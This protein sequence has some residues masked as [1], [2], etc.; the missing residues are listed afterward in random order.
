LKSRGSLAKAQLSLLSSIR[1]LFP[2]VSDIQLNYKHPQFSFLE[3]KGNM[4]L[5]IFLPSASLAFEY[6]GHHHFKSTGLYG[7]PS[8][9]QERDKEK[10]EVCTKSGVTL[11]EVPYWWDYHD[12]SLRATIH[13][14]RP[15][16][17]PGL[18]LSFVPL[19]QIRT[20]PGKGTPIP[21]RPP[22]FVTSKKNQLA[23]PGGKDKIR[24]TVLQ[25]HSSSETVVPQ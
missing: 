4:E 25:Q 11:I 5:D 19:N 18:S 9:Y 24:E 3:S 12:D 20:D 15:D 6:Q 21:S 16:I 1:R 8:E 7:Q 13:L 10:R 22:M 2:F 17:F 23:K 14:H